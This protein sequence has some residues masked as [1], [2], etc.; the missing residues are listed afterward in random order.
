MARTDTYTDSYPPRTQRDTRIGD[1]RPG[2]RATIAGR[3]S[4][5]DDVVRL[6][7]DSGEVA[8]DSRPTPAQGI[9]E[10]TGTWIP[11][12]F[13]VETL[14]RLAPSSRAPE[15]VS[16][17]VSARARALRET[18]E[19]FH[20][21]HFIEVETPL[22]VK[23]P[24]MEPHLRAFTTHS[25]RGAQRF[26]PT[27]PEY[28]MKRL[29]A[30][31]QERIYQICKAF[32]DEPFACLHSGEFTMVEW[33]RAYASYEEIAEDAE[34]LI[35]RLARNLLG[36]LQLSY[37][38]DVIDVSTPWERLTVEGAFGQYASIVASPVSDPELFVEACRKETSLDLP[39]ETTFEDAFFKVFLERVEPQLG[40]VKPTI[41]TDYPASMAALAKCPAASRTAERFEIYV[42]G[43]ELANAF[44]ELNDP[45]EQRRRLEDEARERARSGMP[46]YA[47]DEAFVNALEAGLPPAG[48]IALGFDRLLM[49]LTNAP[50]I[51]D[52][53]AFPDPYI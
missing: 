47:I 13:N 1:L 7:D 24:G 30:S 9:V 15:A 28:G 27:S 25:E 21:R 35:A 17:Q 37:G 31:G 44:T 41:L 49:L 18:R 48:G 3:L 2:T 51:R 38:E 22:L 8:I 26:L 20:D 14:E 19:F 43:I 29:L 40:R 32:R 4:E 11:P 12:T 23:A 42:G 16:G 36:T 53:L 33:Y 52:V 6:R 34:H 10:C 5:L 39:G 46:E 45:V 50:H